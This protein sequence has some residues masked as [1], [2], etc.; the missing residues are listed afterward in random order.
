ML[1]L[2]LVSILPAAE[3]LLARYL[4]GIELRKVRLFN[5]RKSCTTFL[6]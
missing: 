4:F 5:A 1:R 6:N 3:V 2:G